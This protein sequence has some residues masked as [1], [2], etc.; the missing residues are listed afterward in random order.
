MSSLGRSIIHVIKLRVQ[1]MP[2]DELAHS[3]LLCPQF[4]CQTSI[5]RRPLL[6]FVL[7]LSWMARVRHL[8]VLKTI[9]C[10]VLFLSSCSSLEFDLL[11][12]PTRLQEALVYFARGWYRL[13]TGI[14]TLSFRPGSFRR[15]G[16]CIR[17]FRPPSTVEE[18]ACVAVV[19]ALGERYPSLCSVTLIGTDGYR[20]KR[21]FGMGN[22][23]TVWSVLAN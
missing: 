14:Q 7:T 16:T 20:C 18:R 11:Y 19:T 21:V 6:G 13:P 4:P 15:N 1:T 5:L 22:G 10:V 17:P 12:L 23:S 3:L 9:K 2:R 8:A